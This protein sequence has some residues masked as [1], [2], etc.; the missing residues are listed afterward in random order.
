MDIYLIM[1]NLIMDYGYIGISIVAFTESIIQPVPP[2]I[3]IVGASAF[4]L[5][6]LTCAIISTIA[7]T[8]GGAVGYFLGHNLGT[9]AFIKLF[10]EKHL[11]RG[12]AF[13]EKYGVWGVMIAGFTPIPYKVA[14]WLSGIFEM[15]FLKFII[16][17]FIGRFFRFL[18]IAYFGDALLKYFVIGL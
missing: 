2:D 3:F 9:P 7:S 5:N 1:E 16:G 8:F 12:E 14:A 10:G 15:S 18:I 6:P 17:T 11:L 13:F 4:G